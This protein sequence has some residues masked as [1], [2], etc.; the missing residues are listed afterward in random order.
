MSSVEPLEIERVASFLQAESSSG[1][2]MPTHKGRAISTA[3]WLLTCKMKREVVNLD[4][5]KHGICDKNGQKTNS[6]MEVNFECIYYLIPQA[7]RS[8][9]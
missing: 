2:W 5:V 9:D 4:I 7:I 1:F 8:K 3:S 6:E